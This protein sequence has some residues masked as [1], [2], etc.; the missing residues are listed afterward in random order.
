MSHVRKLLEKRALEVEVLSEDEVEPPKKKHLPR[1]T[2]LVCDA[3]KGINQFP[4]AK[5]V[6]SHEHEQNVCRPCY[7][8][9]LENEIDSKAWDEVACPE[10][11]ITLTYKEVKDMTS[12]EKF[13]KYTM[14][15][16][17]IPVTLLTD[18]Y[19]GTRKD[20][21]KQLLQQ[22]QNSDTASLPHANP[23]R[24]IRAVQM[25]P[26][27]AV[28]NAHTSI[29]LPVRPI[30]TKTKPAKNIRLHASAKE[31]KKTSSPRMK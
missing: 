2:C 11:P 17:T 21:S 9:H 26:F 22:T 29:V 5:R 20:V 12:V 18:N 27:F 6:S 23:V 7:L 3:E 31:K 15:D 24:Y 16:V 19:I 1:R 14:Q 13:A 28:S 25:S 10:C 30:G 4:S 8:S